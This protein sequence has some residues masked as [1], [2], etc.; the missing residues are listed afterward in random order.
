MLGIII[1]LPTEVPNIEKYFEK[2]QKISI[3]GFSGYIFE[4]MEKTVP[5]L[6][7]GVGKANAA[8]ATMSL[9]NNFSVSSIIN[10][11]SAGSIDNR[12]NPNIFFVPSS[13]NYID[14]DAI[15]FGYKPN[16]V[17]HEPE[18]FEL[19]S[20]IRQIFLEII[21]EYQTNFIDGSC[22]TSD[23]FVSKENLNK[24][25]LHNCLAVDMESTAIAQVCNKM[26]IEFACAKFI[27]D[28][29]YENE[30]SSKQWSNNVNQ[31]N[32]LMSE[33]IFNVVNKYIYMFNLNK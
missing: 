6:F 11:S 12:L 17:P 24:F 33:I 20:R 23:S 2:N 19:S 1:S 25:N 7:S 26:K 32:K 5:L 22:G 18:S 10:I 3:N 29:I 9:I 16:Q 4:V 28:S 14:V 13:L 27:S 8:S 30:T 31:D 21:K 15:C